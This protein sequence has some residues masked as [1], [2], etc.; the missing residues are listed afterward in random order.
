MVGPNWQETRGAN[1]PGPAEVEFPVLSSCKT[2]GISTAAAK[3]SPARMLRRRRLSAPVFTLAFVFLI[4]LPESRAANA[5]GA[6]PAST[7]APAVQSSPAASSRK[8]AAPQTKPPITLALPASLP[9]TPAS[10]LIAY[11]AFSWD[12]GRQGR[13]VT[14]LAGSS[15][16]I[17]VSTEDNGVWRFRPKAGWTH[18]TTADGVGDRETNTVVLDPLG[19]A[20]VGG[21]RGGVS[22][23]NGKQWRRYSVD[24]GLPGCHVT[25]IASC[26]SAVWIATEGGLARYSLTDGKW[27]SFTRTQGLPE[28]ECTSLAI[29]Q[30]GRVYAATACSG[31]AIA[32]PGDD[33]RSWQV[34]AGPPDGGIPDNPGGAGF[35]CSL[36][37]TVCVSSSG[38]VWAGTAAG[39]ARFEPGASGWR[40]LRGRNWKARLEQSYQGPAPRDTDTHSTSLLEDSVTAVAASGGRV[41]V[42]HWRAGCEAFEEGTGARVYPG[43]HERPRLDDV[44]AILPLDAGTVLVGW[45]GGGV[46][47]VGMPPSNKPSM[48]PVGGASPATGEVRTAYADR[49][50][51]ALPDPAPT[52]TVTEI[53]ALLSRVQSLPPLSES[54]RAEYLGQDWQTIGDW[55]GD[56]HYG[57]RY[58]VLFAAHAPLDDT[59]IS[60]PSYRVRAASGANVARTDHLRH[61]LHAPISTD[62][63]VL[64]D[65]ASGCRRES[66]VDDHGEA[67]D[68]SRGAMGVWLDVTVPAGVSRASLYFFNKD[69]DTW[70]NKYRD[71]LILVKSF[72]PDKKDV[73]KS[74]TLALARVRRFWGGVWVRFV[75]RAGRYEILVLRNNSLNT[76]L[77]MIALDKVSGPDTPYEKMRSPWLR[78]VR[79]GR[80]NVLGDPAGDTTNPGLLNLTMDA[81][82]LLDRSADRDGSDVQ[83]T[84][85]L[86]CYRLAAAALGSSRNSDSLTTLVRSWRWELLLWDDEERSRFEVAMQEGWD[87][88]V[89]ANPGLRKPAK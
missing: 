78:F 84:C 5:P 39:L 2:L 56:G 25:A 36:V 88:L 18:F 79:Y 67:Y 58:A 30:F 40:F 74:P 63:R 49:P 83:R 7:I 59:V 6:A 14:G 32:G 26:A 13:F 20:W 15:S 31:L 21:L 85:R 65:P 33:F 72:S 3:A 4:A 81:W 77:P 57:A 64:W 29:D 1:G 44:S 54:R 73:L 89:A 52:P 45:Y 62:P 53:R 28:N 27:R 80:P 75:L 51:S 12:I 48:A 37:N 22:V 10:R 60:D 16:E 47:L 82:N 35:P 71:Y 11:P 69:N 38:T 76:I 86:L 61:W 68:P 8:G 50:V 9:N 23:Y 43:Q 66:E 70:L 34:V 19:R 41:F 55:Y 87:K 17:W 46:T 42:G 24:E